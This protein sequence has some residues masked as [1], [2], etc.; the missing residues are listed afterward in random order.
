MKVK[1]LPFLVLAIALAGCGSGGSADGG[2]A[3]VKPDAGGGPVTLVLK[4]V[5]GAKYKVEETSESKGKIATMFIDREVK[6]VD[7]KGVKL[8]ST[9]SDVQGDAVLVIG[10]KMQ[11]ELSPRHEVRSNATQSSNPEFKVV[12]QNVFVTVRMAPVFPEGPIKPGD[13]WKTTFSLPSMFEMNPEVKIVGEETIPMDCTFVGTKEV[14]GKKVAV[15][16][17]KSDAK[18]AYTFKDQKQSLALKLDGVFQYDLE[19]GMLVHSVLTKSTKSDAD[20]NTL[21]TTTKVEPV[22]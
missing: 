12:A 10:L 14:G 4:P 2:D 9:V 8:E 18:S 20:E 22:K 16:F 1:L 15:L 6:S 13:T 21:V 7:D 3:A 11:T 17:L 19:T 5:V